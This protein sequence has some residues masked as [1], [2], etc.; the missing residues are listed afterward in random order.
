MSDLNDFTIQ[1]DENLTAQ[2]IKAAKERGWSPESLIADCVEQHLQVALRHRVLIDRMEAVDADI[3]T[4][5]KFVGEASQD[6]GGL[7]LTGICRFG[8]K[9]K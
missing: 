3:A 6:S 9:P 1:L 2:L 8:R 7:D 5:A 4:L